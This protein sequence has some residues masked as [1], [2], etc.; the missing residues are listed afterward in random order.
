MIDITKKY[1]TRDGR[2]VTGLIKQD[3]GTTYSIC[4]LI[5]G[6]DELMY[7]DREGKYYNHSLEPDPRDLVLADEP[8]KPSPGL[9][10]PDPLYVEYGTFVAAVKANFAAGTFATATQDQFDLWLESLTQ[11]LRA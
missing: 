4:G 2:A 8:E 11:N 10:P 1:K 5:A 6:H 3:S 7:W 9:L